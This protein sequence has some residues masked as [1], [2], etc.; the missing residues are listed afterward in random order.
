[1]LISGSMPAGYTGNPAKYSQL[2]SLPSQC[3]ELPTPME[4]RGTTTAGHTKD[5]Q[6][7]LTKPTQPRATRENNTTIK[8]ATTPKRPEYTLS[9]ILTEI[10]WW[11]AI[12][13]PKGTPTDRGWD[14][15]VAQCKRHT[16]K[17]YFRHHKITRKSTGA[18][19]EK[20]VM[21]PIGPHPLPPVLLHI[22]YAYQY[23]V[24]SLHGCRCTRDQ[25]GDSIREW[26]LQ[27]KPTVVLTQHAH[28]MATIKSA[29]LKAAKAE[30][31]QYDPSFV[32]T[33][34]QQTTM[35]AVDLMEM[36][37]QDRYYELEKEYASMPRV[38]SVAPAPPCQD[39]HLT[40]A[41]RQGASHPDHAG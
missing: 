28:S 1:L 25:D 32:N 40:N 2:I 18:D 38:K 12:E 15:R 3:R 20:V 14:T 36:V 26:V 27:W 35:R 16:R 33:H 31:N 10:K 6:T 41:H 11:S 34:W 29:M 13:S 37:G 21:G 30:L 9:P 19:L 8:R 24:E 5:I 22:M 17:A 7:L 4:P 39:L 23:K